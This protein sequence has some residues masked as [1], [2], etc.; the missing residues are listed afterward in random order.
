MSGLWRPAYQ[1]IAM[2]R[3]M[4]PS[5]DSCHHL[6]R[7]PC[8]RREVWDTFN[9][10]SVVR[11]RAYRTRLNHSIESKPEISAVTAAAAENRAVISVSFFSSTSRELSDW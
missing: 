1:A 5:K 2:L 4:C 3:P 7:V 8:S 9:C 10:T 11:V 6:Q